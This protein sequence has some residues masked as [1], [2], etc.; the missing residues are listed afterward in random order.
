M[1]VHKSDNF[2]QIFISSF[3]VH[4]TRCKLHPMSQIPWNILADFS[5]PSRGMKFNSEEFFSWIICSASKQLLKTM[6]KRFIFYLYQKTDMENKTPITNLQK[7]SEKKIRIGRETRPHNLTYGLTPPKPLTK[8]ST[9]FNQ[10]SCPVP[11]KVTDH[12]GMT[13]PWCYKQK[14]RDEW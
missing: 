4:T 7:S 8:K 1:Y 10:T 9:G 2:S 3:L 14:N 6:K 5:I 11:R 12:P 13:Y